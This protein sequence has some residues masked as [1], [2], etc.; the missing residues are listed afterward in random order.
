MKESETKLLADFLI[1]IARKNDGWF[2]DEEAFRLANECVTWGAVE[3]LITRNNGTEFLLR[4]R[5]DH[6]NGWHIPGTFIKRNESLE[7][8]VGRVGIEDVGVPVKIVSGPI[9][10]LKWTGE[11][12]YARPL[13]ILIECSA[14][15]EIVETRTLKW[16]RESPKDMAFE[17]HRRLLNA[18]KEYKKTGK[19]FLML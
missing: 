13:S 6:F 7:N 12:L 3:V 8:A 5:E 4:L 11:H 2:P 15:K 9:A 10:V 14:K 16:F 1:R 17:N 19:S 18:F